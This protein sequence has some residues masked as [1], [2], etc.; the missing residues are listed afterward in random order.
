MKDLSWP[1]WRVLY[2]SCILTGL[3]LLSV[4]L[5]AQ[6]YPVLKAQYKFGSSGD[7]LARSLLSDKEGNLYVLATVAGNGKQV[8]E[9]FGCTDIW[10]ASLTAEAKINWEKS[11][12]GIYCDDA[13]AL[14]LINEDIWVSGSTASFLNH[15]EQADRFR[16]SDAF[17]LN[18]RKDGQLNTY[19]VYGGEEKDQGMGILALSPDL[20]IQSG[21]SFSNLDLPPGKGGL[22]DIWVRKI[23]SD[24]T[25]QSPAF[26]AGGLGYDWPVNMHVLPGN[27][28]VLTANT[29]YLS[30]TL[31]A[32]AYPKPWVIVFDT[33][34]KKK[35]SF[36]PQTT[37]PVTVT[38]SAVGPGNTIALAGHAIRQDA[39]PQFW[40]MICDLNG[41]VLFEKI[42]GGSGAEYISSI[43]SCKDGGWILTGWS[44][45]YNL[46]N[47]NIKGGEDLWVIRFNPQQEVEWAKTWGGPGDER[48]VSVLEYI[49]GVYF[50]L[51]QRGESQ[52]SE[53]R[54]L[55]L[56][57]IEEELCDLPDITPTCKYPG[58]E[59]RIGQYL[60]FALPTTERLTCLW[61]F[62][63]GT[64]SKELNPMKKYYRVGL[65]EVKV[66]YRASQAC[67]RKVV[68]PEKINIK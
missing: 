11:F 15:P 4:D 28:I 42:W 56:L 48:G 9:H 58:L 16:S 3:M 12:G 39:D 52:E 49:P 64:S 62:G 26:S 36:I 23:N 2:Y 41:K 50:V 45:Y 14:Q 27:E 51:G 66:T 33:L 68:F 35:K 6:L 24:T 7:D 13:C 61:D 55:W 20:V 5:Q 53:N 46:E 65:Y 1:I 59:P 43:A 22:S 10:L 25:L 21:Y 47:P 44:A 29:A 32:E 8:K 30:S 54:D 37:S 60:Q 18:V 38:C 31:T 17:V 40:F 67:E 63:D 57:K 34:L 19:Q